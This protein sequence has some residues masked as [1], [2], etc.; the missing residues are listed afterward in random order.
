MTV[1]MVDGQQNVDRLHSLLSITEI[2]WKGR[3]TD[4]LVIFMDA[5]DEKRS[6]WARSS[7]SESDT[8]F[9]IVYKLDAHELD[10]SSYVG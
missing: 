8:S 4:A 9:V 3:S 10:R 5:H 2:P 7:V 1:A 6:G